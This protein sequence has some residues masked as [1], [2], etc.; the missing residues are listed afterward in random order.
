MNRKPVRGAARLA[1]ILDALPDALLLVDGSGMI[2][3]AN[4]I[5]LEYF[6]VDGSRL[7]GLALTAVL[8]GFGRSVS[9]GARA[10]VRSLSPGASAASATVENVEPGPVRTGPERLAARRTD[11]SSFPAEVTSATLPEAGDD[12]SLLIVRDLTG[13]LDVET[14][15]RRQQRQTELI[16]RAASEGIIGIDA[17]GKIVLVNPAAARILRYRAGDLGG[18]DLHQLIAYARADGT[19]VEESECPAVDTLRTG[20][21]HRLRD[22]TLWRKDGSPVFV[23]IAT[24]PVMESD[25]IV[26]AVMTFTDTSELRALSRRNEELMSVLDA[27]LRRPLSTVHRELDGLSEQGVGELGPSARRALT[28]IA[29]ELEGFGKLLGD[30]L[31]YH[32]LTSGDD[33][34]ERRADNLKS[35]VLAAVDEV[36]EDAAAGGIDLMV[37]A[38]SAEV[39][40]D[41]PRFLQAVRHLLVDTVSSSPAGSQVV[42]AAAERG[43]AARIEIRGPVARTGSLHLPIARGIVER[44]GGSVTTH[45]ITGKGHTY[46]LELPLS[47]SSPPSRHAAGSGEH[48]HEPAATVAKSN[49]HSVRHGA[50][51]RKALPTVSA[52]IPHQAKPLEARQPPVLPSA[53]S[54]AVD[55][56]PPENQASPPAADTGVTEQVA[57]NALPPVPPAT[58]QPRAT[59]QA[60]QPEPAATANEQTEP[61][62]RRR[63][64]PPKPVNSTPANPTAA[65]SAP[66]NST[67]VAS[68]AANATPV[69]SPAGSV[70]DNTAPD[71]TVPEDPTPESTPTSHAPPDPIAQGTP[72]PNT[73]PRSHART[74][75]GQPPGNPSEHPADHVRQALASEAQLTANHVAPHVI[76][77]PESLR[78]TTEPATPKPI[79]RHAPPPVE[80]PS[81][82]TQAAVDEGGAVATAEHE[83]AAHRLLL[84]PQPDA[85]TATLLAERGFEQVSLPNPASV[86]EIVAH[87]GARSVALFVDPVAAPITRRALRTLHESAVAARLPLLVTA[88]FGETPSTAPGPDPAIL[89]RAV[90]PP[91][92]EGAR[93]LLVESQI[94]VATALATCLRRAGMDVLHASSESDGVTAAAGMRPDL[95]A[96]D[97][98]LVRRR[99][100]GVVDW[101]RT[102][103]RLAATPLVAYTKPELTDDQLSALRLGESTLALVERATDEDVHQRIID[104]LNKVAAPRVVH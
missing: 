47:A 28:R 67:P 82:A 68:P 58:E 51:S 72:A 69:N 27:E 48:N 70:P 40:V 12:L 38:D 102:H 32:R 74:P 91:G 45:R 24:A 25:T 104:L 50:G 54:T 49:G 11:G 87:D 63:A 26:G 44:H 61:R 41:R 97:L 66:A 100:S 75:A 86:G 65:N 36:E 64:A 6:E 19:P 31:D 55:E 42:I 62:G 46:V 78:L 15:L 71:N 22:E 23:D 101:L 88:G 83:P 33:P 10:A 56:A 34:L 73:S 95:V 29:G 96:M 20:R 57:Q 85:G 14:E 43:G 9:T 35:L 16:L 79:G 2:V 17:A 37:H 1:A 18:Q 52:P 8:P 3:N 89:L 30:V 7:V 84:W 4:A 103:E 21:K 93:V 5:A 59:D 60:G 98:M 53:T 77:P 81:T 94:E 39:S 76:E 80:Q 13:T 90:G 92:G 99:R